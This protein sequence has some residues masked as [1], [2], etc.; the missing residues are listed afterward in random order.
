MKKLFLVLYSFLLINNITAKEGMWLPMLL[1]KINANEMKAM[2]L[3][4]SAEEIYS[5]NKSSL[6]DAIVLF[7]GGCTAEIVSDQGLLLTNH[8]CGYS[9][10]QKHSTIEHDYLTDGFWATKMND[11]LKNPGLVAKILLSMHDVTAQVLDGIT[12]NTNEYDRDSIINANIYKIIHTEENTAYHL[13]EIKPFYYGNQFIL[14]EYNVFRDV[15]LVG[16]PPSNI[17]KFGGDTDNW[18]WPRHTGDF[19]VFRIYVDKNNQPADISEENQPY[20]PK[21]HLKISTKGVKEGDFTM[22]F[23]YPARTKEYIS[24]AELK[25]ITQVENPFKIHL[26]RQKLDIMG[27]AMDSDAQI[28]IQ[29]SAKYAGVAN[30]WKKWIGESKGIQRLNALEKKQNMESDFVSWSNTNNNTYS[31]SILESNKLADQMANYKLAYTYFVEAAYYHDLT[32]YAASFAKLIELSEDTSMSDADFEIQLKSYQNAVKGFYKDYNVEVDKKLFIASLNAYYEIPVEE[33]IQPPFISMVRSKYKGS[34][35]K[36]ADNIYKKSILSSEQK[37]GSYLEDGSRKRIAKLKKDPMISYSIDI[38]SY[39]RNVILVN[40]NQ[41]NT[42]RD[43]L[44]R[45]YMK[46]LMEFK[47]EE[48]MY[49][50]ANS[51]LRISYGKVEA[52]SPRNG[53]TYNHFT[54]LEGIMEKENPNI[55]DYVVEP[56]LKALYQSKDYGPYA[57]SDGSMHVCFIASNHTTGGNSG[58]PALDANGNLIGINFD[59]NWEGTMSDLRY[60][61]DQCRNIMLDIR[62]CL[63]IIDKFAGA[64]RLINEMTFVN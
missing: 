21:N 30:G 63:F 60:D 37:L 6:K 13:M 15:R 55:Y 33:D 44:D 49:P 34:V 23:G 20:Q 19:S 61:P 38:Y 4:I 28:R 52:Y 25:Y 10:I 5:I 41:F 1:E 29:Y 16:T 58:S 43:S 32:N 47:K 62:Y 45:V 56:K 12:N 9:S 64:K 2:G 51:T 26:R 48:R 31:N 42:L 50:D 27:D 24:S 36:F 18:M 46:G 57:D 7:G 11:E 8:H 59:R 54:S 3:K 35:S 53:V 14:M 17:G 40:L 22:I 39:F